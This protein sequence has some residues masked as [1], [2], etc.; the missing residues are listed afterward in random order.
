MNPIPS[1]WYFSALGD[2]LLFANRAEEA[3]SAHRKCVER[4][5]DL[6]W[7]QFGLTVDYVETG[8]LAQAAAQAKEALRI[9][10]KMTAE[11]NT[12]VRSI[13]IPK[14]RARIVK[15]LREAGLK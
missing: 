2:S 6:I 13:G 8:K 10:P 12:Y 4:V 1:D 3:L 9:N 11:D 14:D 7:C 15:A 5:P